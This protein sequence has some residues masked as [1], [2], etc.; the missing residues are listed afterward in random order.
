MRGNRIHTRAERRVR[1]HARDA[2]ERFDHRILADGVHD[3]VLE[4]LQ[5]AVLEDAVVD[6]EH[7]R[8]DRREEL[9]DGGDPSA[10]LFEA[11]ESVQP[12]VD[13]RVDELCAERCRI[14]LVD[15]DE[16]TEDGPEDAEDVDAAKREATNWLLEREE[17]TRRLWGDSEE[18]IVGAEEEVA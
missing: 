17:V 11:V 9:N 12:V 8:D 13:D 3:D 2:S 14:V 18:P 6:L 1:E 16:W 7:V 10:A 15:G 5:L 4:D